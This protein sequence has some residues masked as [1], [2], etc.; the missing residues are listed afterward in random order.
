MKLFNFLTKER[1]NVKLF[2]KAN[3]YVASLKR[4]QVKI[5][6]LLYYKYDNTMMVSGRDGF[7]DDYSI[8]I[9]FNDVIIY[10]IRSE[11]E[12]LVRCHRTVDFDIPEKIISY[13][14]NWS[15]NETNDY[16]ER[17]SKEKLKKIEKEKTKS[18]FEK[19]QEGLQKI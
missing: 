6:D 4:G 1:F 19:V 17:H 9:Y 8:S 5:T 3:K 18:E 12:R 13:L 7:H 11:D 14:N 15:K 10:S 2:C 16:L